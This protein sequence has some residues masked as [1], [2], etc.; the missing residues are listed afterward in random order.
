MPSIAPLR[1][2]ALLLGAASVQ[3]CVLGLAEPA[4]ARTPLP[5]APSETIP[6]A[7]AECRAK[8]LACRWS[9]GYWHWRAGGHVWVP[10]YWEGPPPPG[11]VSDSKP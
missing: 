8:R 9:A 6:P 11:L 2:A 7:P 3:G 5:V 1:L 10:G 4:D